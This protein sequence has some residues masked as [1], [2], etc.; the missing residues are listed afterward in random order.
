MPTQLLSV[1]DADEFR[2]LNSHRHRHFMMSH[3]RLNSIGAIKVYR[4]M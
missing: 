2:E 3:I 1:A 4:V